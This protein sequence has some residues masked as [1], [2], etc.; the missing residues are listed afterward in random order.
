MLAVTESS[1]SLVTHSLLS[2]C[3]SHRQPW[4]IDEVDESASASTTVGEGADTGNTFNKGAAQPFSPRRWL[5][6]VLVPYETKD[7]V[8]HELSAGSK[9][10]E[11]N[12]FKEVSVRPWDEFTEGLHKLGLRRGKVYRSMENACHCETGASSST[13]TL[14]QQV[15]IQH[16]H[17]VTQSAHI[18]TQEAHIA[19]QDCPASTSPPLHLLFLLQPPRPLTQHSRSQKFT[20]MTFYCSF[21]LIKHSYI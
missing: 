9:F 10:P 6:C 15:A 1:T 20:L 21:F 8:L 16:K 17:I 11:I 2:T 13:S 19:T 5:H 18:A 14:E 7:S 3:H 12:T 4:P